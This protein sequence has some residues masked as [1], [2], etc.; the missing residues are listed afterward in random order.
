MVDVSPIIYAGA[1][2]GLFVGSSLF[3]VWPYFQHKKN[4]EEQSQLLKYLDPA[5]LTPEQKAIIAESK[6]QQNFFQA[7]KWRLSFGLIF[8]LVFASAQ[9][10]G[11]LQDLTGEPSFTAVFFTAMT[12]AGFGTA[13]IDLIRGTK[14]KISPAV[15][16]VV[17]GLKPSAA[18]PPK[19]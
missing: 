12:S 19:Q 6:D 2:G 1:L 17:T 11:F 18:T 16:A 14:E 13:L 7:Y 5:N 3:T 4:V 8:G 15:S 9:V 10:Q